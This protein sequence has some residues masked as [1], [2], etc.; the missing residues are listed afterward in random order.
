MFLA[1]VYLKITVILAYYYKTSS[2]LY[3]YEPTWESLDKRP[4]PQ[5]YDDAKIGVFLHWGV[6]SVPSFGSEWFWHNWKNGDEDYISFMKKN[7]P[8]DFTYQSFA[9]EFKAE[10]FDPQAWVKLFEQSGAKYVV[11][12]SKHHEGY[13][14]WPSEYSFSWNAR[15]IGPGR[16]LLE[17]FSNA[18]KKSSLKFG[19]YHSLYEWFNL[20]YVKDK[21]HNFT[22]DN[23][24]VYKILPEL[25]ELVTNFKPDIVWSDGEWESTDEYW[26]STEF[27][28]WLYNESPVRD[29][30]VVNDRWGNNT[31]CQHGDFF[32]CA[33]GYNPGVLQSH[34]WE[35]AMTIDMHSWGY[36]RN[37]NVD[38][39]HTTQSLIQILTETVSCGGN[40]LMNVGPRHDGT[41]DPI[42]QD[43]LLNLGKWLITNGEAIYSTKPWL[44]QKDSLST[45]W[46]TSKPPYV[47]AITLS[48]PQNNTLKLGKVPP[49]FK[50][51]NTEVKL[52]GYEKTLNWTLDGDGV[53]IE[54]PDKAVVSTDWAWVVKI[55]DQ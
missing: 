50:D 37:A 30:V 45:T 1:K 8:P 2:S 27:L 18:V 49:T 19:V 7:Y 40:I 10:F 33:D 54:F 20:M 16:N 29:R 38:D 46:F 39:Y 51:K 24:V 26:K 47:Y 53:N 25:Y 14:L 3:T 5:W 36:R 55:K 28:A 21:N 11:I 17:E 31:R 34:K 23:F 35:N 44:N 13:T 32:T 4:L 42:F 48:W 43:R 52:L 9:K 22:T 41:I 15:D 12:T 6:Y